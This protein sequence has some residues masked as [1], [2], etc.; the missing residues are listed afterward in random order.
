MSSVDNRV[1]QMKFD[2]NQFESGVKTTISSLEKLK[3]S[4]NMASAAKS[5]SKL[6]DYGKTFSVSVSSSVE[7][8]ADRLSAMGTIGITVLSNLTTSAMQMA[9]KISNMVISPIISGGKSRAL[10]IEQAKFQLE[11][12]GIAWEDIEEDISYGVQDTAYGLDSAAKAASQLTASGV[13]LGDEMKS[14]LRGISG[15][16]AMTNSSYDDIARIFT[17]VAG[18]GRLMSDQL[19]QLGSRGLN[20]A[21]TL[22]KSLGV[23]EQEVR[24]MTSKGQ[25]DF[26]TFSDAMDS[27][28]GEHAKDANKTFT[29][30]LS[31]MKAAMSRIGAKFATPAFDNLKDVM[32]ALIPVINAIN[33]GLD[34]LVDIATAGMEKISKFTVKCLG[35]LGGLGE[36]AKKE[37]KNLEEFADIAK[38]VIKGDFG[39]G[40]ER[41]KQLEALGYSYEDVQAKVNALLGVTSDLNDT[42]A[43]V[44]VPSF[45]TLISIIENFIKSV[46]NVGS[47]ALKIL[48]T[49]NKAFKEVFPPTTLENADSFMKSVENLTSKFK[50]TD[51][52]AGKLK[53]SFKGL[54]AIFDIGKQGISA[55]L[56]TISPLTD[57]VV[58]FGEKILDVAS[59]LGDYIFKVDDTAKKNDTFYKT[60]KNIS[61]YIKSDFNSLLPKIKEFYKSFCEL[62]KPLTEQLSKAKNSF[63]DFTEKGMSKDKLNK[64]KTVSG[65]FKSLIESVL[66]VGTA[67]LRI[68]KPISQAFIEM[69]PPI[70]IKTIGN[71]ANGLSDFTAKLKISD[72][73][74][75]KIKGTFKGLFAAVDI[76]KQIFSALIRTIFPTTNHFG[77]LG[78]GILTVTSF[79]GEHLGEL[80]KIIRKNDTF[81]T[82]LQTV[83]DFI[84][85]GFGAAKDKVHELSGAFEKITGIDFSMPTFKDFSD[86]A[87]KIKDKLSNF[88]DI[89]GK[90]KDSVKEF[91]NSFGKDDT[92]SVNDKTAAFEMISSIFE[93]LSKVLST[94][95]PKIG[96]ALSGISDAFKDTFTSV[97][98]DRLLKILN[99]ATFAGIINAIN[100]LKSVVSTIFSFGRVFH[101][102]NGILVGVKGTLT[103]Y[104]K[105]IKAN[106]MVKYAGAIAIL[107][108]SLIALSMIKEERL[109]SALGAMTSMFVELFAAMFLMDKLIAKDNKGGLMKMTFSLIM[110]STAVSILAGV[111]KKLGK[112]DTDQLTKGLMGFAVVIFG[113]FGFLKAADFEKVSIEKGAGLILIAVALNMM[114]STVK[115]L[116]KLDVDQLVKGLIGLAV[117][118]AE[119]VGLTTFIGNPTKLISTG[120]GLN[121]IAASMLIFS[122]AIE[123]LGNLSA[124]D[125]AKGLVAMAVALAEICLACM[126]MP[127]SLPLLSVGLVSVAVGLNLLAFALKTMGSMSWEEVA[128]SLL[129]LTGSL[130]AITIAMIFMKSAIPGAA[131]LLVVAGAL[132]VLAP[133]LMMFGKMGLVEIGKSL[134]MLAGIFAVFGIASALLSPAIPTMLGLAGSI[135]L[136]GVG[137]LAAGAGLAL[138]AIGIGALVACTAELTAFVKLLGDLGV[139]IIDAIARIGVAL[140]DYVSQSLPKMWSIAFM[141]VLT[142]LKGIADNIG[143][144]VETGTLIL[145]NFLKGLGSHIDEIV[146]AAL[147]IIV[148]FVNGISSML[149]TIIEAGINLMLNFINGM[150]DG[151]RENTDKI[152]S[153]VQNLISAIVEFALSALQQLVRNIPGVGQKMVDGLEEAK[154]K[155]REALAPQDMEKIGKDAASATAD[156]IKS[157]NEEVGNAGS[158]LG[159]SVKNGISSF[160]GNFGSLGSNFGSAFSSSLGG[161]KDVVLNTSEDLGFSAV[162][163]LGSALGNFGSMG[164]DFGSAFSSS[165]G[166]T[167]GMASIAVGGLGQ[168][169]TNGLDLD[170]SNIGKSSGDTYVSGLS[171]T[172][173]DVED[174]TTTLM[175]TATNNLEKA[176]SKFKKTGSDNGTNY[177]LGISGEKTRA[178]N[179]GKNI[180][181]TGAKGSSSKAMEYRLAGTNAGKG[182]AAGLYDSESEVH[183]AAVYVAQSA[184]NS[185]NSTLD[186]HSPS[187]EFSK[188]GTNSDKGL[189]LG[190][191]NSMGVVTDASEAVGEQTKKSLEKSLLRV[192]DIL[193]DDFDVDPTIRPVV[194]LSDVTDSANR[195][196][197]MFG[198]RD[199][200]LGNI[201]AQITDRK[202]Q[203]LSDIVSKMQNDNSFDSAEIVRTITELRGDVAYLGKAIGKMQVVMDNGALVGSL[204]ATMDE[205]LG[206]RAVYRG[207]SN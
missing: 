44:E 121:I 99:I 158:G 101:N 6:E 32:N 69:F 60:L 71:L 151:I 81:Y 28:Y 167:D 184:L 18:N 117:L 181:E 70:Q 33:K 107:T 197:S 36:T 198:Q 206:K 87:Q 5:L 118:L 133:I 139:A 199:L 93:F 152:L 30:A 52:T 104:T 89:F 17:T 68:A 51:D 140:Y 14:S 92:E 41:R 34:P 49:V 161:T 119:I 120:I 122:K 175:T 109:T 95:S 163:G 164:S 103:A 149:P 191:M 177:A 20:A 58:G 188:V 124:K 112:L 157:G 83:I 185:M 25:I 16:A 82:V 134:L 29:G 203:L 64:I 111:V 98:I 176:N 180:A 202:M 35:N 9:S 170:F 147:T 154:T 195:I 84:K 142:F 201:N 110:I 187:R 97:D 67:I 123:V 46:K 59:N 114:S 54:F 105:D 179:A 21:A 7:S 113:L 22:A 61:E 50:M 48:Q 96:G 12:L 43:K 100:K 77:K 42:S 137:L 189:A 115:K 204:V 144:I 91:F 4:L 193:T 174:S 127:A 138:A 66:N 166:E 79:L 55:V 73:T 171:D 159:E 108:A 76:V 190:L 183:N 78:E 116:G 135:A 80:D 102:L 186:I 141:I 130:A 182:F 10:N 2:N 57:N 56:K 150:A 40:E 24:E 94:V 65:I 168:T 169:V 132:T 23:T 37:A 156:G 205:A 192:S 74:A 72:E 88:P 27:A 143:A 131:A 125:L 136:L 53:S 106:T 39:N 19:N 38:Q 8:I 129:T 153:A 63:S 148:K 47:T 162:G 165:L 160:I 200:K 90:A 13:K 86:I 45:D 194:D 196:N 145:L 31:N 128:K 1:V 75:D 173:D 62:I 15:V 155:A 178:S 172:T 26:K 85:S 207:R 126:F 11:G 3:E 146:V